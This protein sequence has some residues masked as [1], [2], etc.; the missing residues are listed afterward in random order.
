MFRLQPIHL[1][2]VLTVALIIFGPKRLPQLGRWIG[3]TF[4]EFRKGA[5][6]MADTIKDESTRAPAETQ[7]PPGAA[8]VPTASS[9]QAAPDAG[10]STGPAGPSADA[11]ASPVAASPS[12]RM[13]GNFCGQC[14]V[15]NAADARFCNKCGTKLPV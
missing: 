11:S 6:E 5:R 7:R 15:G 14:G 12:P 4:S 9:D 2:V 13:A 1:V 10:A 3:R 8:A